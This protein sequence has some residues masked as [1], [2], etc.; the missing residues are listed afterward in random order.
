[1]RIS[2]AHWQTWQHEIYPIGNINKIVNNEM[3]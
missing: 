3:L 2:M 1:M